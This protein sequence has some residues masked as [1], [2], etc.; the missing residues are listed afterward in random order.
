MIALSH[1]EY[2]VIILTFQSWQ[3]MKIHAPCSNHSFKINMSNLYGTC[4]CF[5]Q[6]ELRVLK[7]KH[8]ICCNS[9]CE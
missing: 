5:I 4:F 6:F 8:L 3:P 7:Q 1:W 9:N 2:S